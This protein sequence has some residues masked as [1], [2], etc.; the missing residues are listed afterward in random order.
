[1]MQQ[2]RY[3]QKRI[4]VT[5]QKLPVQ[6][7]KENHTHKEIDKRKRDGK[8]NENTRSNGK[9]STTAFKIVEIIG[10]KMKCSHPFMLLLCVVGHS[11]IMVIIV[12][13]R[14]RDAT[15]S[16]S[17]KV[18]LIY[19]APVRSNRH[20]WRLRY[21][22]L[23]FIA[24]LILSF[25]L[26]LLFHSFSSLCWSLLLLLSLN[27]L[28][29]PYAFAWSIAAR[30]LSSISFAAWDLHFLSFWMLPFVL[31]LCIL[32]HLHKNIHTRPTR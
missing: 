23:L 22:W 19:G 30:H 17:T 18:E 29:F 16:L 11:H 4:L 32:I 14:N 20:N 12:M 7:R 2:K 24:V 1:M 3:A 8:R 25:H 27:M 13:K 21:C 5:F 28:V 6:M 9:I 26:E 31:F 10:C 15:L